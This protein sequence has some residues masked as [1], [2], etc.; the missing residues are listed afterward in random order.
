MA[1]SPLLIR[2]ATA[3][4][5]RRRWLLLALLVL[6]HLVFLQS[7][8]NPLGRMLFVGHV[9]LFFL[10]QPFI[11]AEQRLS[12]VA[13]FVVL[14]IVVVFTASLSWLSLGVWLMLLAGIIGGKVILFEARWARLRYLLA[15][16]YLVAALFLLVMPSALPVIQPG[17]LF[18][19]LGR[20]GTPVL[21]LAMAFLPE[22]REAET[23]GEVVDFVYSVFVFLLLAVLFLGSVA[24]MLLLGRGYVEALFDTL[25]AIGLG[26]L[27][28][29]WMWNPRAG[30]S[31]I[32]TVFSRYLLSIGL[33]VE[34]WLHT[35]A[36]L[37]Q[38]QEDPDQFVAEACGEM[39]HRLPWVAGGIWKTDGATGQFGRTEGRHTEFRYGSFHLSIYTHIPLSPSLVWHFNL[40][41]QLVGEFYADRLRAKQLR[42]LAHVQAVHETGARL[43]HD[44]KN[45]LQSLRTLCFA[46]GNN[47]GAE[48]AEYVALLRRQLPAVTQRLAQTLEKL[49]A[50]QSEVMRQVAARF[51]WSELQ[52]RYANERIDF[53]VDGDITSLHVPE[54]LFSS[55]AENLIE[56]ALAKRRL[57]PSVRVVA[58]LKAE[59]A[60][61]ALT[62]ADDGEAIAAGLARELTHGPVPSESGFGI[63][64]YQAA[65]LAELNGF[66]LS[67]VENQP[68]KIEFQLRPRLAGASSRPFSL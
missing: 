1:L 10:W 64:L 6:L 31:G 26:L 40:L 17:A 49:Q 42:H 5:A 60:A 20:W 19:D 46:A 28:L 22:Q 14:G 50:P 51:W 54:P 66:R 45:L 57:S 56:N 9:G 29:G 24:M 3:L 11:R 36:D 37:A 59:Q 62:V 2:V 33:P 25:L 16:A 4:T 32:G 52:R 21:L 58:L 41:A 44:I 53:R 12:L 8:G 63:G 15:L 39:V 61:A 48:S 23:H 67:L 47:E 38:K 13:L 35:L 30:F 65:R 55:V 43:T 18:G 27:V 7:P 34:R 68:G